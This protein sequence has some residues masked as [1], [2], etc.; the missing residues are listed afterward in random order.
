MRLAH[1]GFQ[2]EKIQRTTQNTQE[3]KDRTTCPALI[4]IATRVGAQVTRQCCPIL[5]ASKDI[6]P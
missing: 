3:K 5:R 1:T 2:M 6:L 4:R